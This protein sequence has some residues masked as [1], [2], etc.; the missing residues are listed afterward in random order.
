MVELLKERPLESITTDRGEEFSKHQEISKEQNL[1]EFYFP[2]A[3]HPWQ[4]WTN[5]NTNCLQREYF[6]KQRTLL[7]PMSTLSRR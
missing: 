2:F 6:P 5:E 7:K 1:V 4:R 3:H